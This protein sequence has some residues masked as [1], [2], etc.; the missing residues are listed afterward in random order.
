MTY[1]DS[2]FY[3][4]YLEVLSACQSIVQARALEY[5][6][7]DNEHSLFEYFGDEPTTCMQFSRQ[8]WMR[9]Q[10]GLK[11]LA[12][13]GSRDHVVDSAHDLINYL[14]FTLTLIELSSPVSTTKNET[15]E[16]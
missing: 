16:V 1:T 15:A 12:E 13:G 8:K 4:H 3:A 9:L 11:N 10:T 6:S 14:A 5:N 2:E 7:P